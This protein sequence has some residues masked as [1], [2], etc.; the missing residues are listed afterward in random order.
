LS[1]VTRTNYATNPAAA[2]AGAGFGSYLAGTGETGTTTWVTGASDGPLGL[3]TYGRRAITAAKTGGSNGWRA[4]SGAELAPLAGVAGDVVTASVYLRY[5]GAG[6]T[7]LKMRATLHDAAGAQVS[8]GDS[9]TLTLPA[10][11][12][13]RVSA[14]ATATA[15]FASVGWWAYH[16]AGNTLASGTNYDVTGALIEKG[17][18]LGS[19][20][21]GAFVNAASSMYS[22]AGT[23]NASA[24]TAK[25]YTPAL[26][27]VAKPLFDPCPRVEIT[28]SDLT[29]T[30]NTVTIWRTADGKRQAVR[31]ARKR[32]VVGS[33]FVTDYE[34]PLGRPASYEIEVTAG[35]NAQASATPATVT[36]NSESGCIQDPL[37]PGGAVPVHGDFGPN[38]EAYLRDQALKALEYAAD[39]SVVQILGSPD[40]VA[41]MGQRMAAGGVDMSMSTGA[42][43]AAADMRVLLQTAPLVL[44]RPLPKWAAALP[45]LCYLAVSK[46]TELPVTEAWG[47]GLIRWELVGDLVAAPTMNVLVPLWT[48]GDVKALWATYQ[49]AQTA[50]SGKTYLDVLKSPSGV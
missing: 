37:V 14:T 30:T 9:P 32:D 44:V 47:G 15:A 49:Q 13:T 22:W 34:V 31:G 7:T 50:L 29:P 20:F 38:G 1:I 11:T 5:S 27:L 43:Q 21:S 35:I 19:Y 33:D 25:T 4:S 28:I 18:A 46:P 26:T 23:P 16:V 8:L 40:P 2:S 6:G 24:S 45:G 17:S 42:A 48:H 41:I 12:W 36:V 39:M 10:N 3:T